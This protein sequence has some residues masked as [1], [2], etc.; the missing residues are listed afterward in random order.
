MLQ[1]RPTT[2]GSHPNQPK[3]TILLNIQRKPNSTYP[4]FVNPQSNARF[5][6]S[7][8]SS[9]SSSKTVAMN[10]SMFDTDDFMID[11]IDQ[12]LKRKRDREKLEESN[13]RTTQNK[14]LYDKEIRD[15]E[16]ILKIEE[17]EK[18][19]V[20]SS[21]SS[22]SSPKKA[23]TPEIKEKDE[24]GKKEEAKGGK[25]ES[26]PKKEKKN[27]SPGLDKL[28]WVYNFMSL[29]YEVWEIVFGYLH[30]WD[31]IHLSR[32]H[33]VFYTWCVHLIR[34]RVKFNVWGK[35]IP[36]LCQE[37]VLKTIEEKK[38][39]YLT[40]EA[41]TGKSTTLY[42]VQTLLTK[43]RR[44][45][46]VAATTG[47]AASLIDGQTLH[48]FMGFGDLSK[49]FDT[50]KEQI[51]R[52]KKKNKDTNYYEILGLEVLIV[53]EISMCS[54]RILDLVERLISYI[55]N[56]FRPPNTPKD[57]R[58]FAG[59]QVILV[60]DFLQ[61]PPVDK[62]I[63]PKDDNLYSFQSQSWKRMFDENGSNGKMFELNQNFRQSGDLEF[64]RL[65][66]EVR[67][68]QVSNNAHTK[69]ESR[70]VTQQQIEA[71]PKEKRDAMLRLYSKL[72]QVKA[73]NKRMFDKLT[74]KIYTY[75]SVN[76]GKHALFTE[77]YPVNKLELRVGAR[78]I[79]I[80]N[81]CQNKRGH[82][83]GKKGIVVAFEKNTRHDP[84]YDEDEFK[85]VP[86]LI[87]DETPGEKVPLY[88]I[89]WDKTEYNR[90]THKLDV[91]A[92]KRQLPIDLG[93][94]ISI[95]RS[96]GMT[97]KQVVLDLD[98]VFIGGQAYV[99]LSRAVE[100]CEIY[101]L[102]YRRTKI[103]ANQACVKFYRALREAYKTSTL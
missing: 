32:T 57:D 103:Y 89:T 69:L 4:T 80:K 42:L 40:G 37:K 44:H 11:S 82:Y 91:V 97:L 26:K 12:T 24:L 2:N 18:Q 43:L 30:I 41:G 77:N 65:L 88:P 58:P 21:T 52:D 9:S 70:I 85:Y 48:K 25:S 93:W 36:T 45:F 100:L 81:C 60:G 1:K 98:N 99:A 101:I 96:Q 74:G 78:V 90:R 27:K 50:Y 86:V 16:T 33:T 66:R 92:S 29:P 51:D 71:L 76:E 8:S 72:D 5:S 87:F 67:F 49:E 15:I 84:Y 46:R 53:D 47:Q 64:R 75:N 61:L 39:V 94:A 68:G 73:E 7:S 38:H 79:V 59:V 31:L 20:E 17:K 54:G 3:H 10:T 19:R 13:K 63:K 55:R 34:L 23:K 28:E 56:Q 83:N 14:I 95:H 35:I 6:S 102:S 62:N 22:S